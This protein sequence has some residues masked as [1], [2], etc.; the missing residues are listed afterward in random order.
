MT[1]PRLC[2]VDKDYIKHLHNNIDWRVSVKFNN[3]PFVVLTLNIANHNYAIPLT[4]QTTKE[5]MKIGKKKRNSTATTF[6]YAGTIEI[7][8]LLHNNMFP[9][10]ES[11]LT[12]IIIDPRIDTYLANEERYIRK[13]YRE[14]IEKTEKLYKDRYDTNKQNFNFL[15]KICCDFAKLEQACDTWGK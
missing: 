9:V 11:V 13:H 5:R 6:I 8:N 1:S 7:A 3:R 14:I 10:P 4:S 15:N 2:T 12:D